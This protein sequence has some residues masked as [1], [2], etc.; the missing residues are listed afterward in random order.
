[1]LPEREVEQAELGRLLAAMTIVADYVIS[2]YEKV[3]NFFMAAKAWSLLLF[4]LLRVCEDYSE[5]KCWVPAVNLV[6]ESLEKCVGKATEE[7]LQSTNWMEGNI[8]VDESVWSYRCSALVGLL[9]AYMISHRIKNTPLE[10]ED[11]VYSCIGKYVSDVRLW[12]EAVAP[13][14]SLAAQCLCLRGAEWAGIQ[15]A[16]RAVDTIVEENGNKRKVGLPDPYY[17]AE[18][19]MRWKLLNEDVIGEKVS[20]SGRSFTIRQFVE[21]IVRRNWP[22]NLRKRWYRIS[23]IDYVDFSPENPKDFYW[24]E[25]RKGLTA[26]RRW[27]HPQSWLS[28]VNESLVAPETAL[29]IDTRFIYLLPY[30]FIFMPHRFTPGRARLLDV[31]LLLTSGS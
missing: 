9:S 12:G 14:L 5:V 26:S 15:T 11:E 23:E 28:L 27:S 25:C 20:F 16:L 31:K 3:S 6:I 22:N 13:A 21:L 7:I 29:L 18:E 10:N 4:H 1:M 17:E 24:W 19:V 30:L 8:F 2:E